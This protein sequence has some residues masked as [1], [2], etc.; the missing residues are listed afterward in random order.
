MQTFKIKGEFIT[1]HQLLKAAQLI[2]SGGEA[3]AVIQN[4]EVQVNGE[5]ETRRGR[6][7]RPGDMV[8]WEAHTVTVD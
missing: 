7:L 2:Q 4:G 3:K 6:K 8:K 1:L 5:I